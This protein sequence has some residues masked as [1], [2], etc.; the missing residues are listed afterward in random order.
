MAN[1]F[2]LA[3]SDADMDGGRHT[4]NLVVRRVRYYKRKTYKPCQSTVT[5][6]SC[7]LFR[8]EKPSKK[9]NVKPSNCR[10]PVAVYKFERLSDICLTMLA[11]YHYPS[12]PFNVR[13]PSVK[14]WPWFLEGPWSPSSLLAGGLNAGWTKRHENPPVLLSSSVCTSTVPATSESESALSAAR[15]SAPALGPGLRRIR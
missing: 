6:E 10:P 15:P 11:S 4:L 13:R 1:D 12:S 9:D 8:A 14:P 5:Y 2:C 7:L 3:G